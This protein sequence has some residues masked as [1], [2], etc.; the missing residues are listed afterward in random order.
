MADVAAEAGVGY[1]LV[2]G[3]PDPGQ[4]ASILEP[5]LRA[6][7]DVDALLATGG[8]SAPGLVTAKNA[9][10]RELFT[11]GFDVLPNLVQL[12]QDGELTFTI[13]QQGYWRGYV[14]VMQLVHYLRYGLVQANYYLTGPIMVDASNADAVATLAEAGVR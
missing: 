7:P 5:F 6:N 2:A 8:S 14:S 10:G 11:A 4:T 13:D 9:V 1:E 3:S 12:I